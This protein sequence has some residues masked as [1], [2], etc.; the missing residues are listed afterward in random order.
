MYETE[1]NNRTETVDQIA[2]EG[3]AA[4]AELGGQL[5]RRTVL[6][7]GEHC[8]E[9]VWPTCYTSC[10][11]YSPREDARCRRFVDGMVRISC[12]DSPNG[13]ILKIR[14]K[15]WGKLWSPGNLNL[16]SV[17]KA[18]NKEDRDYRI[19]T[20]IAGLPLPLAAK[21][22]LVSKRYGWKKRGAARPATRPVKATAFFLECYSP[23]P[24]PVALSLTIRSASKAVTIPFQKLVELSPG[25][26]RVRLP[27]RDISGVLDLTSPFNVELTPSD[28]S[29]EVTLYFGLLDFVQEIKTPTPV[30]L[31]KCVV[32]DL[33]H[34]LWDGVLVEDG[35][36]HLKLRPGMLRVLQ[37]L[38]KRGILQSVASKNNPAEALAVLANFGVSHLFLVPQ[39]GWSPKSLAMKE[40]AR[41][42]NIGLD[43]L[44]FVDDS[45][46]ERYEVASVCPTVSVMDAADFEDLL[47]LIPEDG[48]TPTGEGTRREGYLREF[49]RKESAKSF[50]GDYMAFLRDCDIRL[51]VSSLR[52]ENLL[53]V[54]ELTQRTNQMNFSG[55]RYDQ[56]V[57]LRMMEAPELD[58]YV[59]TCDDK[60]G[61]YGI[62]GFG[63]VDRREPRLTDLMFSCR[64]QAKRI[65][66][67]FL[68][69][70][71]K[72]H[73]VA[74]EVIFRASYRKTDRNEPS[75]RVFSDL[76]LIEVETIEGVTS[77]MFPLGASLTDDG[78]MSLSSDDLAVTA[79]RAR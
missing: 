16:E 27:I 44:I 52:T 63:V 59:L 78:V 9:C 66:H 77:L 36:A 70:I 47:K 60:F 61:S 57:L 24:A 69:F 13:Y 15:K 46:F 20:V 76:G 50:D 56:A 53:R 29:R 18:R 4:F 51:R 7:W 26:N 2:P 30:K 42:L 6:S 65:E 32:W 28:S 37:A 54:H 11:L 74:P 41:E 34:T 64:I 3:I 58:T 55:N 68:A 67:A 17:N 45:A 1:A 72:S 5:L 39:I 49:K 19:G 8:T 22:L 10:D 23:S 14:F 12:P 48:A 38:D 25:F 33:D 73:L 43:S 71:M 21:T 31:I 35:A 75:G 62:V 79:G 40:I